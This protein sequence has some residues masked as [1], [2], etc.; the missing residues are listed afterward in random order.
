MYPIKLCLDQ[1][2]FSTKPKAVAIKGISA[3]IGG[4]TTQISNRA[5]LEDFIKKVSTQGYTFCTATFSNSHRCQENFVQQQLIAMD[6]DNDKQGK[7]VTFDEIKKRSDYYDLHPLFAYHSLRSTPDHPRFRLLFL[8]DVSISDPRVAR[9]TQLAVGEIF[10]EADSSCYNDVSKMYFGGK[11]LIYFDETIPMID[12]D[13]IFRNLHHCIKKKYGERHYKEKLQRFSKKTGIS[14]TKKGFLDVSKSDEPDEPAHLTEGTGAS[15][16][17]KNGGNSPNTIIMYNKT[18]DGENPPF[19]IINFSDRGTNNPSVGVGSSE[20]HSDNHKQYRSSTIK[21]IRQ[22]CLLYREFE[23]G[24]RGLQ[25]NESFHLLCNLI[26]VESGS[27]RFINIMSKYPEL[28]DK[29]WKWVIDV[30]RTEEAQKSPTT[31]DRYCPYCKKC[32]HARTIL[33]T[34]HPSRNLMEPDPNYDVKYYSLEEAQSDVYEVIHEAYMQNDNRIHIIKAQVGIGKSH[35]YLRIMEENPGERFLIAAPTNL[36]KNELYKKAK[37]MGS[38]VCVTPSLEEIKDEIPSEV[39]ERIQWFYKRGQHRPVALY[40]KKILETEGIT[41]LKEYMEQKERVRKSKGCLITT[42][43]YMLT[44][45]EDRLNEFDNIIVDEDII[46]KSIITNQGEITVSALKKLRRSTTDSRLSNKIKE[47]LAQAEV[48][49]C[50][51][52]DSFEY[53]SEEDV[54]VGNNKKSVPLDI[55]SF[56]ATR[57]FYIRRAVNERNLKADTVSF[58][59]PS[60]LKNMK[61]IIVSATVDEDICRQFFGEDRDVAFYECKQAQYMGKML[62]YPDKSMSRSSIDNNKGIVSRLVQHFGLDKSHLITFKK[63]KTGDLHFG[64]TEGSNALEGQD[65]LVVGTPYHAD[66]LYKLIAFTLGY[67]FD[68]DEEMTPQIV[69]RNGYRVWINTY[70]NENLRKVHLWMMDSELDQATGRAR[71]LRHDC[72]VHLFSRYPMKQAEIVKGFDYGKE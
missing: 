32:N 56:C 46:F 37:G 12:I 53:E 42:H 14:L 51:K 27:S 48:K 33:T 13:T 47:L 20:S 1:N 45:D 3:R 11:E 49:S 39:W 17:T 29:A 6:F 50:I 21:S 43:R 36:L 7:A 70:Q 54:G 58:L 8:N 19:Y 30:K 52:L 62:Q 24:E 18:G 59:K 63:E 38:N 40:I 61:H 25:H 16:F 68:E 72:T 9:A 34:A 65:I 60:A 10:P 71:L 57:H 41:C 15:G 66:F 28:Y 69:Y 23:D 31:C 44:M 2:P 64:N 5:D 35:S 55:A 67:D 22:C 26:F 4:C